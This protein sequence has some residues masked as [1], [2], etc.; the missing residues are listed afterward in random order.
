MLL[1]ALVGALGVPMAGVELTI[2]LSLAVLGLLIAFAVSMPTALS[3]GLIAFFAVFHGYVHGAEMP[4]GVSMW[5][6]GAGFIIVTAMLHL[7]G[8]SFGLLRKTKFEFMTGRFSGVGIAMAG[9][10]ILFGMG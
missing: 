8:L 2:G 5:A 1:G 9:V 7:I 3:A 10:G 4:D 6:Y